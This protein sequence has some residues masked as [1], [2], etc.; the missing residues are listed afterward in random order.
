MIGFAEITFENE[1]FVLPRIEEGLPTLIYTIKFVVLG[2]CLPLKMLNY[3]FEKCFEN[4]APER[5]HLCRSKRVK[6]S[7]N[8]AIKLIDPFQCWYMENGCHNRIVNKNRKKKEN[9]II[10]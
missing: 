1:N 10:V 7:K 5:A 6:S 3:F 9:R 2:W 4:V 8:L